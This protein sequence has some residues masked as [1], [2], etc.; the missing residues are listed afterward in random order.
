[1]FVTIEELTFEYVFC[2]LMQYL[3]LSMILIFT[4]IS[5]VYHFLKW[6]FKC[7]V[8]PTYIFIF[9]QL[10]LIKTKFSIFTKYKDALSNFSVVLKL[11]IILYL[12]SWKLHFCRFRPFQIVF[13]FSFINVTISI[14][15]H[16]SWATFLSLYDNSFIIISV[17]IIDVGV[18]RM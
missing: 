5:C 6:K 13:E 11:P 18:L 2:I 8:L 7:L 1:M 17:R 16:A 9:I 14:S 10:S 12:E 4:K 15:I 3:T